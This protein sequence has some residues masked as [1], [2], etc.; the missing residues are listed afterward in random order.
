ME[1][2]HDKGGWYAGMGRPDDVISSMQ[3]NWVMANVMTLLSAKRLSDRLKMEIGHTREA[4]HLI[5]YLHELRVGIY[6]SRN[7]NI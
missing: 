1:P 7:E 2:R 3:K 4:V 5:V 6:D